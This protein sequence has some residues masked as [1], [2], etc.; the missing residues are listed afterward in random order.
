MIQMENILNLKK[1]SLVEFEHDSSPILFGSIAKDRVFSILTIKNKSYKLSW[2]SELVEPVVKIQDDSICMVGV[3]LNFAIFNFHTSEIF[4]N[5]QLEYFFCTIKFHGNSM[6]I[7]TEMEVIKI[8]VM[9]FDIIDRIILPDLFMKF[10]IDNGN[11]IIECF[12][13]ELI[14][15]T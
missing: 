4:L 8:D 3:D 10:Y 1:V 15:L 13:G 12:G 6:Y 9:S 11:S 7:I 5:L 2:Q 14:T